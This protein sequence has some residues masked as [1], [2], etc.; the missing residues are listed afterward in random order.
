MPGASRGSRSS[1]SQA[2]SGTM[3]TCTGRT[4]ARQRRASAVST[5][6]TRRATWRPRHPSGVS[7][8][9]GVRGAG[10]GTKGVARD[11]RRSQSRTLTPGTS[12]S[13]SSKVPA[14]TTTAGIRTR[15]RGDP[16]ATSAARPAA[17]TR[18]LARTFAAQ[19]PTV[20]PEDLGIPVSRTD[21]EAR[22]HP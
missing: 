16:G 12:P 22:L 21:W 5:G 9:P 20:D 7:V 2:A 8:R 1:C 10:V 4:R 17:L 13:L 11:G 15:I 6:W 18:E 14:T 19:V 3:A